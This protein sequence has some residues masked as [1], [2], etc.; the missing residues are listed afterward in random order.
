M[1]VDVGY[2]DAP[3]STRATSLPAAMPGGLIMPESS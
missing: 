3:M 1:D 2:L